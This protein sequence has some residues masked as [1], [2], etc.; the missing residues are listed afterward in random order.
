MIETDYDAL[1]ATVRELTHVTGVDDPDEELLTAANFAFRFGTLGDFAEEQTLT[2]LQLV[3]GLPPGAAF[4]L[5]GHWSVSRVDPAEEP[6]HGF[7]AHTETCDVCR[8]LESVRTSRGVFECD[9]CDEC[10]GDIDAHAVAGD[11]L[12]NPGIVCVGQWTRLDPETVDMGPD[13][14]A[15]G[16]FEQT[17]N[18]AWAASWWAPL[19]DG[20]FAVVTRT[21]LI[22]RRAGHAVLIRVDDYTVCTDYERL[23]DTE[24][25]SDWEENELDSD[26]PAFEDLQQLAVDSFP[27][28]PGEWEDQLPDSPQFAVPVHG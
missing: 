15:T 6:R 27:P 14:Y 4:S 16:D 21:Y 25:T 2:R 23:R 1:N 7:E 10:G 24:T 26:G 8:F 11:P 3:P 20:Q 13:Y 19:A 28:Q 17:S 22:G 12:G 9:L 5:L 18:S